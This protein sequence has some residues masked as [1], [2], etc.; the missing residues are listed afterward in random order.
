MR[1]AALLAAALVCLTLTACGS[2]PY[3]L[4]R[5]QMETA[6]AEGRVVTENGD[7]TA[8]A[9]VWTAFCEAAQAGET[10]EVRLADWYD[11]TDSS[12]ARLY[13]YTL[14]FDGE[15]YTL[16]AEYGNGNGGDPWQ[17]SYTELLSFSYVPSG[18]AAEEYESCTGYWLANDPEL[19]LEDIR[20][21]ETASLESQMVDAHCVYTQRV[22]KGSG[23]ETKTELP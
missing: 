1:R 4:L 11:A 6:K 10:A 18:A 22:P 14:D 23:T 7:V 21:S 12:P 17:D 5:E 19:T 9:E 3:A 2:G 16:A 15:V 8:G 20:R 13:F